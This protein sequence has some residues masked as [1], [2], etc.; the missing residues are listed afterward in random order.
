MRFI[1]PLLALGLFLA[2]CTTTSSEAQIGSKIEGTWAHNIP[3]NDGRERTLSMKATQDD[4]G[5]LSFEL[6]HTPFSYRPVFTGLNLRGSTVEISFKMVL[7]ADASN[8]SP[9]TLK[10]LLTEKH[11]VWSGQLYQSWVKAPVDVTLERKG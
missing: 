4:Q 2:G 10:Y 1:F 11:G 5:K 7:Y 9:H 6:L 8:V 3:W